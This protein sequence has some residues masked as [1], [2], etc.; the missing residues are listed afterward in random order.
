MTKTISSSNFFVMERIAK[1]VEQSSNEFGAGT[2]IDK[3]ILK[4]VEYCFY[5]NIGIQLSDGV[6]RKPN[7]L[8]MNSSFATM[9]RSVFGDC[10]NSDDVIFTIKKT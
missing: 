8:N 4:C 3:F 5:N 10:K 7:N 2:F 9:I 6:I 1:E